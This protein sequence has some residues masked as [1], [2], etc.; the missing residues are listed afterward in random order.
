MN[1]STLACI[2]M[3]FASVYVSAYGESLN[4]ISKFAKEMCDE[5][6]T[7]GKITRTEIEA[8]LGGN[9]GGVAKLLGASMGIDGRI[10]TENTDFSGLPYNELSKEMSSA[11]QCRKELSTMLIKGRQELRSDEKTE[12]DELLKVWAN[13]IQGV[14]YLNK[15]S[16][17]AQVDFEAR[18]TWLAIPEDISDSDIPETAKGY[19]SPNG[20]PNFLSNTTTC[21]V[22]LGA[23][24]VIGNDYKCKAYGAKGSFELEPGET[25]YFSMNDVDGL[26]TDNQG[27]VDIQLAVSKK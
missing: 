23:L 13:S 3:T 24:I 25:V 20:D 8:Q 10:K 6:R 17:Y 19:I 9:M 5:I 22:P 1:K 26:Y 7:E 2:F 14:S 4:D 12:N 27:Y 16:G 11:R 21:N 18:G 15:T